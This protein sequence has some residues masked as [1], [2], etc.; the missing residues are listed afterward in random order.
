MDDT[1][2]SRWQRTGKG[3][4]Q[5]FSNAHHAAW[6][7]HGGVGGSCRVLEDQALLL[8]K[9]G[10]IADCVW[11]RRHGPDMHCVSLAHMALQ[12]PGHRYIHPEHALVLVDRG[13]CLLPPQIACSP[14]DRT[15]SAPGRL[16]RA[17]EAHQLFESS[18]PPKLALVV[19]RHVGAEHLRRAWPAELGDGKEGRPLRRSRG[20]NDKGDCSRSAVR[21]S[22]SSP[23]LCETPMPRF[24][25]TA[26]MAVRYV[27]ALRL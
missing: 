5:S 21:L 23:H 14:H 24:G 27:W 4:V 17:C 22:D 18:V 25:V 19:S 16:S 2:S 11:L 1:Q 6:I 9:F 26:P 13:A 20:S 12:V 7:K 10:E 3:R 15:C 8:R